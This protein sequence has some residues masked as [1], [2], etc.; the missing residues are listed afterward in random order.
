M[1]KST[2]F[3]TVSLFQRML[4]SQLVPNLVTVWRDRKFFRCYLKVSSIFRSFLRLFRW[5]SWG[6]LDFFEDSDLPTAHP[7]YAHGRCCNSFLFIDPFTLTWIWLKTHFEV[8]IL[9]FSAVSPKKFV[10]IVSIYSV[11]PNV[12][13]FV[14]ATYFC[15]NICFRIRF[16]NCRFY[17]LFLNVW[18]YFTHPPKL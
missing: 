3:R 17:E 15:F 18:F 13:M 7:A 6:V 4:M 11:H 10:V 14:S 5:L 1:S 8:K 2:D 12:N 16:Y 9:P